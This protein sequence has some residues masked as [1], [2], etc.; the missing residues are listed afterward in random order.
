MRKE[1]RLTDAGE[2]TQRHLVGLV[3]GCVIIIWLLNVS[4]VCNKGHLIANTSRHSATAAGVDALNHGVSSIPCTWTECC[5]CRQKAA[6]TILLK[7][8]EML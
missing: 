4:T 1:L 5:A 2:V 6:R 7:I 3:R 8:R